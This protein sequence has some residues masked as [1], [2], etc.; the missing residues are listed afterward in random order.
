MN[1]WIIGAYLET[2]PGK[3]RIQ[4]FARNWAANH[5]VFLLRPSPSAEPF[6]FKKKHHKGFEIWYH[7]ALPFHPFAQSISFAL[8]L[9]RSFVHREEKPEVIIATSPRILPCFTA[10]YMAKYYKVPFVLEIRRNWVYFLQEHLPFAEGMG[11]K[12]MKFLAQKADLCVVNS[13]TLAQHL[14][15]MGVV[16]DKISIVY[17][18]ISDSCLARAKEA[19]NEFTKEALQEKLGIPK[20]KKVILYAGDFEPEEGLETLVETA[21]IITDVTDTVFLFCGQGSKRGVIESMASNNPNVFFTD[22][23][24]GNDLWGIYALADICLLPASEQDTGSL[25]AYMF[26]MMAA[27]KPIISSLQGE[28]REILER[29]KC[30]AFVKPADKGSMSRAVSALLEQPDVC[31]KLGNN[32]RTFVSFYFLH[33]KL[34]SR[35]S[36]KIKT[37]M[38]ISHDG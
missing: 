9:L 3:R 8:S 14:K 6:S 29:A 2:S 19:H 22:L 28:S 17:N 31:E 36:T 38:G 1:I 30:A 18:G 26:E 7:F 11:H 12:S 24:E 35:Y 15:N 37:L 20:N 27:G 21:S 23:P 16:K 4:G 13:K 33:S 5:N 32:A 10:Y 25:R 34:A